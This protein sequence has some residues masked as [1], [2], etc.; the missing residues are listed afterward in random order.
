MNKK[1]MKLK[2]FY[3]HPITVFILLTVL[4]VLLSGLLSGLEV[5]ATYSKLNLSTGKLESTLI[6][7]ENL[8][9]YDGLK[10]I[11]GN[12]SRNFLSFAPLGTLLI[13]LIGLTIGEGSGFI[14]T[15]TRRHI[16]K[17]PKVILTFLVIFIATISSLINE[18]GY[19]ILIPLA[20]I[21]SN[22]S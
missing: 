11:I 19:A 2:K 15:L 7:V 10:Y 4:T 5:Q 13:A 12:V 17:I 20:L 6:A 1:K 8:C 22:N 3:F 14:E 21:C 16:S 18:V 9:N